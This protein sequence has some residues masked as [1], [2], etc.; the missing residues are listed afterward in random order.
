MKN[1]WTE[2]ELKAYILIYAMNADCKETSEEIEN[3]SN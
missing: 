2:G 1:Y 3:R